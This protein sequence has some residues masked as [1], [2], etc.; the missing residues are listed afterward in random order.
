M[1]CRLGAQH[2]GTQPS[3]TIGAVQF[4]VA[5]DRSAGMAWHADSVRRSALVRR[6]GVIVSMDGI[7]RRFRGNDRVRAVTL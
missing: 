5:C 4:A 6:P 7:L 2:G 1:P 3:D